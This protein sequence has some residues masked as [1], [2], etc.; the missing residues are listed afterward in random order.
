MDRALEIKVGAFVLTATAVLVAFVVA[1]GGISLE[2]RWTV[3]VDFRFAGAIHPGAAVKISGVPVGKVERVDFLGAGVRD[4]RGEPVLVRLTLSLEERTREVVTRDATF[5]IN[6]QGVLG[7]PYV[8]IDP[9]AMRGP[10]LEPGAGPLRGVDPPRTDLLLSRVFGLLD[11]LTEA[12]R[13]NEASVSELLDA[14]AGLARTAD[15]VLSENRAGLSR[16]LADLLAAVADLR[17]ILSRLAEALEEGGDLDRIV[18]DAR[19][20]VAALRR[21]LPP[22]LADARTAAAELARLKQVTGPLGEEDTRRLKA[23]LAHYETVGRHLE[24]LT[25]DL[26]VIVDRAQRGHGTVGALL[27]DDQIYDDLKELLEDLKEHPWK[28]VWK[29]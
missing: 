18:G 26:E 6:T 25:A 16:G 5:Y 19:E 3:Q 7:E 21:D 28:V 23:A 27:Q 13:E 22:L 1:L 2:P 10:P 8:E 11:G 20:T 24:A 15:E 17:R 12:M 9:G 4:A 29:E 14:G